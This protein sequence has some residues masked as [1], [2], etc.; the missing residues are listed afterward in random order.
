MFWSICDQLL[1]QGKFINMKYFSVLAVLLLATGILSSAV[2]DGGNCQ[3]LAGDYVGTYIEDEATGKILHFLSEN[4]V[5]IR[6]FLAGSSSK[7]SGSN[8]Q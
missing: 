4:I 1:L 6:N 8:E 3:L 2:K 7:A 5:I